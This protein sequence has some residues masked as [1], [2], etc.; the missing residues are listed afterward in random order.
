MHDPYDPHAVA[1]LRISAYG[2]ATVMQF[3]DTL[4]AWGDSY[5]S[6]YTAEKV[7]QAEQLYV[8]ADMMLGPQPQSRGCPTPARAAPP[9][10]PTRR[11]KNLDPFSNALVNVENVI[12]AP[13][14][15]QALVRRHGQTPRCRSSRRD[16]ELAAV[17]HSAERP[18]ARVLG[19]GRPAALQHPPLP[20]PPGT[21]AAAA[22]VCAADQPA[23]T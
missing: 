22:P 8:L 18:A 3:L 10:P 1:S 19:H 9:P 17:L 14:P 4:I 15:P 20:E 16:R 7:S 13:E 21:A 5:Y 23:C 6:Q 12:V 2:K 11:S